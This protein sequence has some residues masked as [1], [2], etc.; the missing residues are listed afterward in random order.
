ME[1]PVAIAMIRNPNLP[2]KDTL[3]IF[4]LINRGGRPVTKDVLENAEQRLREIQD[5]GE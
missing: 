5:K 2:L 4:L 1:T 3:R